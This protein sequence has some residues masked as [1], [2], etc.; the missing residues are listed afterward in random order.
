MA[1]PLGDGEKLPKGAGSEVSACG[2]LPVSHGLSQFLA[3]F[4]K[5]MLIFSRT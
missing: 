2:E 4:K 1:T 3:T 5:Q